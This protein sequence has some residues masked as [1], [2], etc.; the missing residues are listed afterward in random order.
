M[1]TLIWDVPIVIAAGNTVSN[2]FLEIAGVR[3]L[4]FLGRTGYFTPDKEWL[5]SV[6][7]DML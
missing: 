4:D 1:L 5:M 6:K 3:G 2:E 7:A